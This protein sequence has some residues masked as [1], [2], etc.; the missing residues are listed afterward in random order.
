MLWRIMCSNFEYKLHSAIAFKEFT[1]HIIQCIFAYS[2]FSLQY[3][4]GYI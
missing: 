1:N 3:T 2:I 4:D